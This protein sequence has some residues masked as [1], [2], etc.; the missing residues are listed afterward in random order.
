MKRT[1]ETSIHSQAFPSLV[2]FWL[3]LSVNWG[4]FSLLVLLWILPYIFHV[5]YSLDFSVIFPSFP[6]CSK[7]DLFPWHPVVLVDVFLYYPSYLLVEFFPFLF[8]HVLIYPVSIS[9]WSSFFRHYFLVYFIEL[10]VLFA[11]LFIVYSNMYQ[12]FYSVLSIWLVDLL[13]AFPVDFPSRFWVSIH[14]L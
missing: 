5:V 6:Y 12:R 4:V 11:L 8:C 1:F 10:F 3:L 9:F 14:V 13:S 2:H 7:I